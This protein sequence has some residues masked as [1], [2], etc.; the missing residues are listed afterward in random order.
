LIDLG[1]NAACEGIGF[2]REAVLFAIHTGERQLQL[3]GLSVSL[4]QKPLRG[5]NRFAAAGEN[6]K[7]HKQWE[8]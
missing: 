1:L 5:A 7:C 4:C 2:L 8:V 6:G 3:L